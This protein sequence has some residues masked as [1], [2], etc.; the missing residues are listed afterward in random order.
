MSNKNSYAFYY[1]LT[2]CVFVWICLCVPVFLKVTVLYKS[3]FLY[4]LSVS[5]LPCSHIGHSNIQGLISSQ[6][7]NPGTPRFIHTLFRVQELSGMLQ[8]MMIKRSYLY[9][10]TLHSHVAMFERF[11]HARFRLQCSFVHCSPHMQQAQL[12]ILCNV[13]SSIQRQHW[14][15]NSYLLQLP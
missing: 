2:V 9:M 15:N 1:G 3:A 11:V 10:Y 8:D 4:S 7:K 12:Q 5:A 13:T 6:W 14:W